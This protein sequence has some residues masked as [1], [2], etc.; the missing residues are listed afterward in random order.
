MKQDIRIV[1]VN[2]SHPGNI[3]ATARAMKNMHFSE[4]VL[5][6]PELFPHSQATAMA[7]GADDV[8]QSA[9]VVETLPQA[10]VDCTMVFGTS[11]RSRSLA[12]S[13]LSPEH[14][15]ARIAADPERKV[16]VVFGRESSG[17]SNAELAYCH[18]H[19][20]IPANPQFSSLNLSQAVQVVVYELYKALSQSV[21]LSDVE[22]RQLASADQMLG[23]FEHLQATLINI[24]F[25]DPKQPKLLLQRLM[26]LFNRA[27]VD[28]TELNI[29]RGILSAVNKRCYTEEKSVIDKES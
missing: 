4:L 1:L 10:L 3:G 16:A 21:E 28:K 26:R 29:L 5:V 27:E 15:A 8:L 17:L 24:G 13:P 12:I 7:A 19:I 23:F 2:P 18:Y 9:A 11:A 22:F 14:C 20:H 25:I 6:A